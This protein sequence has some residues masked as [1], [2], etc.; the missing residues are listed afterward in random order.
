MPIGPPLVLVWRITEAC[1][2]D[3]GFC[4]YARSLRRPRA[5]ADPQHVLAFGKVLGDYAQAYSREVLVSWLGGEPLHWPHL[6]EISRTFKNNFGLRLSA[7]TNGTALASAD[8]R[9][10][11]AELLDELTISIDS[12]GPVHDQL[13]G[14]PGLFNQLHAS[15]AELHKLKLQLKRRLRLRVNTILMRDTLCDFPRLC[16]TLADWGIEELTFN[17][18]GGRDRPEFFPDH[19]LWPEHI[20]WLR[21]ELPA[22]RQRMKKRG[23]TI[24]GNDLYLNRLLASATN[25][26]LPIT[27]CLPGQHFLFI[28]EH[29]IISPCSYTPHGY[30]LPLSDLR[31]AADLHRLP[32]LFA[33]RQ[34][35]Q[36]LAPCYDCPSTQVFG[37]FLIADF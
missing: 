3:C 24:L 16:E 30:G 11:V 28:D 25:N 2:L 23:L 22:L 1:D 6:F 17:A 18:L 7:T 10:Q 21:R 14:A 29:G 37:K 8:V 20:A 36:L 15:L 5:T 35:Q 13:R 34:H 31:S 4:A 32:Q 33:Q 27:N 19:R 26:Q 12:L 9:E